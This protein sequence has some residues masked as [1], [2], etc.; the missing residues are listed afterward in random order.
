MAETKH[1]RLSVTEQGEDLPFLDWRQ[2]VTDSTDSNMVKLDEA[3]GTMQQDMSAAMETA[4]GGLGWDENTNSL[5]LYNLRGGKIA[6]LPVKYT[7]TDPIEITRFSHSVGTVEVGNV[8]NNITFTMTFSEEAVSLTLNGEPIEIDTYYV[9]S[10]QTITDTTEFTLIAKDRWGN[11]DSATTTISFAH[12]LY[13]GKDVAIDEFT[14][15]WVLDLSK[16]V[17]SNRTTTFTVNALD[18]EYVYFALPTSYGVPTFKVGG[19]AGGFAKVGELLFENSYKVQE[20]YSI[21]RSDNEG[22]VNL[23]VE[24]S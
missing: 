6:T 19:F 13:Y 23:T 21:Y 14:S 11:V 2:R 22:L 5:V 24:V 3:Y 9:L 8:V 20:P 10:G 12:G 7:S 18:G 4:L 16:R 1:L 15:A 17:K